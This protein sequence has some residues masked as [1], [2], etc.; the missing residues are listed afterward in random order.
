MIIINLVCWHALYAKT[1]G[2]K[3]C[4]SD[5]FVRLSISLLLIIALYGCKQDGP[6]NAS[7]AGKLP[8]V[9]LGFIVD[10]YRRYSIPDSISAGK[11]IFSR[12]DLK[13][14]IWT[15]SHELDLSTGEWIGL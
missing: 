7:G 8:V 2:A 11:F 10:D 9:K 12:I 1:L 15:Q 5:M 13:D 14:K 3:P 4:Y 6:L